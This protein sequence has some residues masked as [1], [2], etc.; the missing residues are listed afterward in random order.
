MVDWGMIQW[1]VS[2]IYI[3]QVYNIQ[4]SR[5]SRA[6]HDPSRTAQWTLMLLVDGTT[7]PSWDLVK[8]LGY[9]IEKIDDENLTVTATAT[10]IMVDWRM[11]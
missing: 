4:C 6:Q 1:L 5:M 7:Q 9:S 2:E 11:I 8:Y 3:Y 10:A